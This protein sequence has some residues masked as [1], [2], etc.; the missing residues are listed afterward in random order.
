MSENKAYPELSDYVSQ[1]ESDTILLTLITI[2]IKL[3]D[4]DKHLSSLRFFEFA[5][6]IRPDYD[7]ARNLLA[8]CYAKIGSDFYEKADYQGAISYLTKANSLLIN[9]NIIH[10]LSLSFANSGSIM[11]S[12]GLLQ[13]GIKHLEQSLIISDNDEVRDRLFA[14]H[15]IF[16]IECFNNSNWETA[17]IHFQ[18]ALEINNND[19]AMQQYK[20]LSIE[21]CAEIMIYPGK[22]II[23]TPRSVSSPSPEMRNVT[24]LSISTASSAHSLLGYGFSLLDNWEMAVSHM[25]RSCQLAPNNA[26]IT[27]ILNI[28]LFV[29]GTGYE[30]EKR[31]EY[32]KAIKYFRIAAQEM[33]YEGNIALSYRY[34]ALMC[35][36]LARKKAM[37]ALSAQPGSTQA[38]QMISRIDQLPEVAT[39]PYLTRDRFHPEH[40]AGKNNTHKKSMRLFIYMNC[41]GQAIYQFMSNLL[42]SCSFA[43]IRHVHN[44]YDKRDELLNHHKDYISSS[45]ILIYQPL[46]N[47]ENG[48]KTCR[49]PEALARH[50]SESTLKISIPYLFNSGLWP[51]IYN[52]SIMRTGQNTI[53]CIKQCRSERELHSLYDNTAIE[54]D[55][56]ARFLMSIGILKDREALTSIKISEF[57]MSRIGN[58]CLFLTAPH[59]AKALYTEVVRQI[60]DITTKSL[61]ICS[62]TPDIMQ[63]FLL[64][65]QDPGSTS[66]TDYCPI[67]YYSH[68][69]FGMT[70]VPRDSIKSGA[71]YY[72]ALLSM[73]FNNKGILRS[74]VDI[75]RNL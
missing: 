67:D 48:I 22:Y 52:G 64:W 36:K 30:F 59:P 55:L 32:I 53:D 28:P 27:A 16:G 2:G 3:R 69:H 62:D 70:W 24:P 38:L 29:L 61:T 34:N 8:A 50:T 11:I 39:A 41:Q 60:W 17:A 51:I 68:E 73:A 12:N 14:A 75:M 4:Q 6:S 26:S 31:G 65:P 7:G 72:R 49:M 66:Y 42:N 63:K 18:R 1:D 58:E 74:D 5:V 21:K 37:R 35:P 45:D 33:A 13:D 25:E 19:E 57:I 43:E 10:L 56:G 71:D 15:S 23:N 9:S 44:Y 54:F 46:F 40:N 20:Q 47:E